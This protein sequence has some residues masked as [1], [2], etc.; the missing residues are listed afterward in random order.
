M[1]FAERA[2]DAIKREFTFKANTHRD[3]E[4]LVNYK[5][6]EDIGALATEYKTRILEEIEKE[7]KRHE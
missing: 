4:K 2:A 3:L 1:V 7:K 5:D 6:Y